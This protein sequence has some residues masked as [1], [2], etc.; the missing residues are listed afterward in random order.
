MHLK[1]ME[2]ASHLDSKTVE[3][4]DKRRNEEKHH[5]PLNGFPWFPKIEHTRPCHNQRR[6]SNRISEPRVARKQSARVPSNTWTATLMVPIS[7]SD[8]D[9]QILVDKGSDVFHERTGY[10]PQSQHLANALHYHPRE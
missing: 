6:K 2:I 3:E 1:Y 4:D 10:R 8:R 9:A 7:D 5:R